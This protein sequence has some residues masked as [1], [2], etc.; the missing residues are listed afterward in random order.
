MPRE[1]RVAGQELLLDHDGVTK[2]ARD[3]AELAHAKAA[4]TVVDPQH[5]HALEAEFGIDVARQRQALHAVILQVGEVPRNV[6]F[7]NGGIGRCRID[8]GDLGAQR[9]AQCDVRG[10]GADRPED[11]PVLVVVDHLHRFV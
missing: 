6:C 1:V 7:G 11:R 9:H 5:R 10:L 4:V 2:P 3:I 8:D